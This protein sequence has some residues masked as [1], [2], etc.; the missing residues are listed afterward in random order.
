MR[1]LR[2]SLAGEHIRRVLG[3]VNG[4]TNYILTEMSEKGAE[5]R[6]RRSPTAQELGYAERD[7][8]ADV[9]GHDAAAKAAIL[10]GVAFSA[11]V[12]A[13]DVLPRGH[14]RRSRPPTSS[15]PTGSA[16]R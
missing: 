14:R 1:A 12:V 9:G 11:D 5:L 16:T 6:R 13:A 15:S 10:A 4:T 8:T 3:I 2:D 7:P